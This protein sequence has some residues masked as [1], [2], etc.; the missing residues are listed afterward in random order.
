MLDRIAQIALVI[1]AIILL[2]LLI[3]GL[4]TSCREVPE[5]PNAQ[6]AT[7][8]AGSPSATVPGTVLPP[9]PT[10]IVGVTLTGAAPLTPTATADRIDTPTAVSTTEPGPTAET[11][12]T[13]GPS[14]TFELPP[15]VAAEPSSTPQPTTGPGPTIAAPSPTAP[16]ATAPSATAAPTATTT[17]GPTVAPPATATAFPTASGLT[18]GSTVKHTVIQG[19]WLLQIARC[20]GVTYGALYNANQPPLPDYILPGMI[21][22]VPSIGSEGPII[23]PPCVV[24]YTVVSGDSWESLAQRY[25]TTAVILQRVNPGPLTV[26]RSIWVPRLP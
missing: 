25:G 12:A 26:G 23:G 2:V 14:A 20:Y 1:L 11:G 19:E 9:T 6:T 10:P 13:A 22:T 4:S 15:T 3:M 24:S 7:A 21:L 16:S 5:D 18:P 8:L 17:P